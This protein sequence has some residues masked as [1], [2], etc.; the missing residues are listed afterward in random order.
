[1]DN[2][3][4]KR[5]WDNE[6]PSGVCYAEHLESLVFVMIDVYGTLNLRRLYV[7]APPVAMLLER[8]NR[9]TRSI[10]RD[11]GLAEWPFFLGRVGGIPVWVDPG[12]AGWE[13]EI[14]EEIGGWPLG[15]VEIKNLVDEVGVLDRLAEIE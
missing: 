10:K 9:F 15:I 1:M 7:V 12:T 8:T 3:F 11:R 5:L 13:V 4:R 6:C 14:V 2:R